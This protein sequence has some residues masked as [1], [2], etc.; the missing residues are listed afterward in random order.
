MYVIYG[1]KLDEYFNSSIKEGKQRSQL[2]NFVLEIR[3]SVLLGITMGSSP[4]LCV[5]L[6]EL[7]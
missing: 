6:N 5:I 2:S 1:R 7:I 4:L 3:F